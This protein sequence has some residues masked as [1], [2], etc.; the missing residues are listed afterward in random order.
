[1]YQ[2]VE[3]S[4]FF[5]RNQK[6]LWKKKNSFLRHFL[7]FLHLLPYSFFFSIIFYLWVSQEHNVLFAFSELFFS[8]KWCVAIIFAV[9]LHDILFLQNMLYQI[10]PVFFLQ[11]YVYVTCLSALLWYHC[12]KLLIRVF[13]PEMRYVIPNGAVKSRLKILDKRTRH[14]GEN[15]FTNVVWDLISVIYPSKI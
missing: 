15:T 3:M 11:R 8:V 2:T 4:L 12:F 10:F 14:R 6:S 5:W 13:N 9:G 7:P 1:M